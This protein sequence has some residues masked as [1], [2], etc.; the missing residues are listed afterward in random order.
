M[1]L[2]QTGACTKGARQLGRQIRLGLSGYCRWPAK[3][4]AEMGKLP[5]WQALHWR[6][7]EQQDESKRNSQQ[8][9][10]GTAHSDLGETRK[11]AVFALLHAVRVPAAL[12]LARNGD[13][14]LLETIGCLGADRHSQQG[15]AG[16]RHH[17]TRGDGRLNEERQDKQ[18]QREVAVFPNQ[19]AQG[20]HFGS[21][22]TSNLDFSQSHMKAADCSSAVWTR[23]TASG[24]RFRY[25][26]DLM[27][28]AASRR[29]IL[30]AVIGALF[31]SFD[32]VRSYTLIE[33]AL[34]DE[35]R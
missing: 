5:E 25:L 28:N 7:A 19:G 20:L 14:H 11:G 21:A 34:G 8:E 18:C 16:C 23:T 2:R 32:D 24:E 12:F 33:A 22:L 1:K 9:E 31:H 15:V 30:Q 29:E 6:K 35:K 10:I 4:R 26:S 13:L 27:I 3:G 17:E